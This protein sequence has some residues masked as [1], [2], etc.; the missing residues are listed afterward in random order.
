MCSCGDDVA[1]SI[2]RAHSRQFTLFVCA[3]CRLAAVG[4]FVTRRRQ[5]MLSCW[6]CSEAVNTP[7]A[8]NDVYSQQTA[9]TTTANPHKPRQHHAQSKYPSST[10]MHGVDYCDNY[11]TRLGKVPKLASTRDGNAAPS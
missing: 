6:H 9:C 2:C 7:P 5:Q 11:R 4:A 3:Q 8:A 10:Q 1:V